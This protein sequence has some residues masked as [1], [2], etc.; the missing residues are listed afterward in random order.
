M[1]NKMLISKDS[2]ERHVRSVHK[3]KQ[4]FQCKICEKRFAQKMGL[5]N[6]EINVHGEKQPIGG[7]Q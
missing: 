6:H 1:C 5:Q 2:L 4:P 3:Y 7:Q